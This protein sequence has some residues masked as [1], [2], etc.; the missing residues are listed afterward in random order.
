MNAA[1][2]PDWLTPVTVTRQDR[3]DFQRWLKA[4]KS[5]YTATRGMRERPED[6]HSDHARM[7]SGS[8]AIGKDVRESV[9]LALAALALHEKAEKNPLAFLSQWVGPFQDVAEDAAA[10]LEGKREFVRQH[11]VFGLWCEADGCREFIRPV[12]VKRTST[13]TSSFATTAV[14]GNR[15]CRRVTVIWEDEGGVW[16]HSTPKLYTYDHNKGKT[17]HHPMRPSDIYDWVRKERPRRNRP[18][19]LI[20]P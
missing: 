5:R 8:V 7:T 10:L 9:P 4:S 15:N 3:K 20:C 11:A 1:G 12:A 13:P 16:V 2:V 6:L 14:C 19:R 17:I 18:A